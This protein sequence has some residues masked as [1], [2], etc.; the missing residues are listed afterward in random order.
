MGL[1]TTMLM[2]L[3][4]LYMAIPIGIVGHSF[5]QV[6]GDRDV[7]LLTAAVRERFSSACFSKDLIRDIFRLF[8]KDE[9][10]ELS[11]DCLELGLPDFRKLMRVL[12]VTSISEER[13]VK[14]FRMLDEDGGGSISCEEF[15]QTLFPI[16]GVQQFAAELD[17]ESG[18]QENLDEIH[19]K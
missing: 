18:S 11:D 14:L 7:L 4:V 9:N 13:I 19:D 2:I 5:S 17:K 15:F 16:Q 10:N 12:H 8:A 6:W 3:S 1:V